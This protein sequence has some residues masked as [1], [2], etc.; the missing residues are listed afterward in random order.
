MK[1][2]VSKADEGNSAKGHLSATVNSPLHYFFLPA[3]TL[4]HGHLPTTV[5]NLFSQSE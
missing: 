3:N 2:F 1:S 5:T 4:T